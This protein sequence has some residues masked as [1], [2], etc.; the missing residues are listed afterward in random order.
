MSYALSFLILLPI[1]SGIIIYLI[2]K[3]VSLYICIAAQIAQ[4]AISGIFLYKVHDIGIIFNIGG[5][6]P[7][8]GIALYADAL[9]MSFVLL[10]SFLFLMFIIYNASR[11][12]VDRMFYMLYLTLQ[13]M[14]AGIFLMDDLFS[15]FV[16]VEVSTIIVSLLIMYKRDSRSMYD[17]L[18]YL[19][20]N[21]FSM[22][23][24][25]LAL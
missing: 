16:L 2:P 21:V 8:V 24:F 12:Y 20:V 9:S 7:P 15:I 10:A 18:I 3:K 11:H 6:A 25:C 17:G 4:I 1:I 22:T 19:L 23:F 13:G 14:L 5:W